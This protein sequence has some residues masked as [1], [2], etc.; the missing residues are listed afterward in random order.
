[1]I[2]VRCRN[3]WLFF[4]CKS[5]PAQ[6]ENNLPRGEIDVKSLDEIA[7][8]EAPKLVDMPNNQ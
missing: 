2:K 3:T 5:Q 6:T 7:K 4:C 8:I 1:M